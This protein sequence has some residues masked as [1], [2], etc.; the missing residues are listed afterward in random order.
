[1]MDCLKKPGLQL[2]YGKTYGIK[3]NYLF[4]SEGDEFYIADINNPEVKKSI[5]KTG[6]G[7]NKFTFLED[8]IIVSTDGGAFIYK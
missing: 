7:I 4:L 6:Y 5:F 1:M 8:K 2:P 3:D